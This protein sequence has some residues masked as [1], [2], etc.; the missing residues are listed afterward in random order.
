MGPGWNRD[1]WMMVESYYVNAGWNVEDQV[2]VEGR[3][4]V[5]RGVNGRGWSI[6]Q[7]MDDECDKEACGYQKWLKE[8]RNNKETIGHRGNASEVQ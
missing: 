3:R 2:M 1:E 4:M 8:G 7:W 5:R 6:G